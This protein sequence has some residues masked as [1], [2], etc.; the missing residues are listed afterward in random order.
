MIQYNNK[1]FESCYVITYK[2]SLTTNQQVLANLLFQILDSFPAFIS[3]MYDSPKDLTITL[4][5]VTVFLYGHFT[6]KK[7][8]KNLYVYIYSHSRLVP[9][10]NVPQGDDRGRLHLP[11][12]T[13]SFTSSIPPPLS[14]TLSC[15]HS[16][17]PS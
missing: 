1:I 5:K 8:K 11:L 7:E 2:I 6:K 14:A 4:G 3:I 9:M 10:R 13:Y 15:L 17:L 12:S 16:V